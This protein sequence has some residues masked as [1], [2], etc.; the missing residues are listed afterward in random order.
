M[1]PSWVTAFHAK[2]Y[3]EYLTEGELYDSIDDEDY[4]QK[5]GVRWIE[6]SFVR[7][8]DVTMDDRTVTLQQTYNYR[9]FLPFWMDAE[10]LAVCQVARRGLV[11]MSG[12]DDRLVPRKATLYTADRRKACGIRYS[13]QTVLTL[14]KRLSGNHLKF[15]F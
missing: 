9:V 5:R 13:K 15:A 6:A 14:C 7:P 8:D 12:L 3:E 11:E 1:E 4:L 2:F 10:M